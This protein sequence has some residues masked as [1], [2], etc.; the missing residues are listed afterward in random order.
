MSEEEKMFVILNIV[1]SGKRKIKRGKTVSQVREVSTTGGERF[2]VVDVC[3]SEKGVNWDEVSYF[4]GKHSKKVLLD[5]QLSFPEFTPLVRFEAMYFK[6]LLLFNT[7]ELILRE[8]YLSGMKI[9]CIINDPLALYSSCLS[10]IVRFASHTT[11]VTNY[12]YRYFSEVQGLYNEYGAGVTVCEKAPSPDAQTFI[13]DTAGSF[14]NNGK[15][16]LFSVTGGITPLTV[17]G[18]NHLKVL[19]PA[20]INCIDFLGA[21]YEMNRDNSLASTFCA[22]F[23]F[24]GERKSVSEVMSELKKQLSASFDSNKS[25]IFC[26]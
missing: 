9:R 1:E 10:K 12:D 19:C 2:Y 15:G 3:D 13:I 7:L 24:Y 8:M 21:V 23:L 6:N 5:R 4:I 18:F 16:Y 14:K 20:Y 11:V 22:D 17:E 26:V 25:I